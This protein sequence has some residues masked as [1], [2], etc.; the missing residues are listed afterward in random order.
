[1]SRN[2]V[3]SDRADIDGV[4]A[5]SGQVARLMDP[6][7]ARLLEQRRSQRQARCY[8]TGGLTVV[9]GF[10]LQLVALFVP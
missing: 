6:Q 5:D 4:R 1:M 7:R 8:V 2:F 10:I 9:V 3:T